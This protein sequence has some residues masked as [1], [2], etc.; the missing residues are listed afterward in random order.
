MA[1]GNKEIKK[2]GDDWLVMWS[3]KPIKINQYS[4]LK[5]F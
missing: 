5:K 2:E 3:T 4:G 1:H